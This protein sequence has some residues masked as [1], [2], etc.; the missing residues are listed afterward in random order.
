MNSWHP[1]LQLHLFLYNAPILLVL[2]TFKNPRNLF[3]DA[4]CLLFF[5]YWC[6]MQC[7]TNILKRP[8]FQSIIFSLFWLSDHAGFPVILAFR[9][10]RLTGRSGHSS[11]MRR[12][13]KKYSILQ[14][15][16]LTQAVFSRLPIVFKPLNFLHRA[17]TGVRTFQ[18]N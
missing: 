14:Y 2:Q 6:K 1:L 9:P 7:S 15:S 5:A 16:R 8:P 12:P 10:F 4:A 11:F 18:Q 13:V 3:I 17:E